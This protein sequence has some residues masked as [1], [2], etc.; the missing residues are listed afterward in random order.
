M[1]SRIVDLE[2]FSKIFDALDDEMHIFDSVI[3]ERLGWLNCLNPNYVDRHYNC[4]LDTY[5]GHAIADILVKL[6]VDEPGENWQQETYQ[7]RL[8]SPAVPGW[9]LTEQWA[10]EVPIEG[11]LSLYYYSGADHGAKPNWESRRELMPR[12]LVSDGGDF[13]FKEFD[14]HDL[15]LMHRHLPPTLPEVVGMDD[16]AVLQARNDKIMEARTLHEAVNESWHMW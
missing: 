6:A 8:D 9:E 4:N 2:L 10:I 1:F 3:I 15:Q 13:D 5:E 11:R 12:F 7:R 14:H 16:V